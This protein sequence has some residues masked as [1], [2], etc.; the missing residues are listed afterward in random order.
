ML[1]RRCNLTLE[2]HRCLGFCFLNW[3]RGEGEGAVRHLQILR[4]KVLREMDEHLRLGDEHLRPALLR[5]V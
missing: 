1:K 5:P 3:V 2:A 4:L